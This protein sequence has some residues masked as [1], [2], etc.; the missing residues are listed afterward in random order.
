MDSTTSQAQKGDASRDQLADRRGRRGNG[1]QAEKSLNTRHQILEAGIQCLVEYGYA[2]SKTERIAKRAGVSRGAM[3]HHFPSRAELFQA[4][5][6]YI[7]DKRAREFEELITQVKVPEGEL[8]QL[9]HMRQTMWVLREFY[10]APSF[11]ALDE[12]LRG[13]RTDEALISVLV[14]LEQQLDRKIAARLLK[15]FPF[16]AAISE[17]R[18][19]LTDLATFSLQ[20]VAVNPA[21][22][23]GDKRMNRLIEVLATTAMREFTAAYE[24]SPEVRKAVTAR[25]KRVR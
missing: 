1:W 8:P 16:W 2:E 22:Y 11:V 3:T 25:L 9:E 23:I 15:R 18:E 21:P 5:A 4:I 14:P 10:T 13:A 7:I 17:T 19:M 24:S 12:L 6:E 20:G